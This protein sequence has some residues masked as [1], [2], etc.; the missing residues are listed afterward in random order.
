MKAGLAALPEPNAIRGKG[1]RAEFQCKARSSNLG[2]AKPLP[3]QQPCCAPW[4]VQARNRLSLSGRAP[5]EAGRQGAASRASTAHKQALRGRRGWLSRPE[6]PCLPSLPSGH[7]GSQ[8]AGRPPGTP[9][10]FVAHAALLRGVPPW[11]PPGQ[12]KHGAPPPPAA[13]HSSS[14][15]CPAA[16]GCRGPRELGWYRRV[17]G[18]RRGGRGRRAPWLMYNWD[19]MVACLQ[20]ACW[21]QAGRGPL[22]RVNCWALVR[23]GRAGVWALPSICSSNIVLGGLAAG[24]APL[25]LSSRGPS[26]PAPEKAMAG[27]GRQGAPL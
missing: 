9:S 5:G 22:M 21:L 6:S 24:S 19:Q 27:A 3:P 4:Q 10:G 23:R 7:Q 11:A 17:A 14:F 25:R 16:A 18:C 26:G 12:E 20:E 1:Q 8:P 2:G 13:P 15:F